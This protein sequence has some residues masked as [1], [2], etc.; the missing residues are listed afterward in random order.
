M[1]FKWRK[2]NR[3]IHR[4]FGYFFFA[5]TIIYSVSGIA[6]NH[7][8][9]WDP[10]YR[11]DIEEVE[12]NTTDLSIHSDK[13]TIKKVI[14]QIDDD[15]TYRSH[16]TPDDEHIKVFVKNGSVLL[17]L[18][19]GTGLVE[20]TVRRPLLAPMNYLH[21]NPI[22]YWTIFSDIYAVALFLLA[23]TGLFIIKGKKGITGRGAWLTG[24]GI[25]VPLIYLFLYFY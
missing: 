25:I 20:Q 8:D 18:S 3:I 2:W 10:N 11:V 24:L 14:E 13:E 21:Y 23:L 15:L 1:K 5:M 12:F 9:D 4:D 16:Y 6:I 22:K 17:N 7:R 19:E